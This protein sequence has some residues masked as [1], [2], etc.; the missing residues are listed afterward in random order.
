M[1]LIATEGRRRKIAE[2]PGQNTVREEDSMEMRKRKDIFRA[3]GEETVNNSM[4]DVRKRTYLFPARILWTKG[5]VKGAE[6]L[7]QSDNLQMALRH[8]EDACSMKNGTGTAQKAS[9]LLDFGTELHGGIHLS[10][11]QASTG[12]KNGAKLRIRFGESVSEAMSETGGVTNATND[13]AARDM[14]VILPGLSM[15]PIGETGFRFVRIDLEEEDAVLEIKKI[16]AV[17][18]YK[19]LEYQ[20]SFECSDPLLNRIWD[21]GA[22]TVHLNAQEYLLEGIKRDRLVWMGDMHPETM[23]ILSVFGADSCV[24]KSLDYMRDATELPGW[25]NTMATYTMWYVITVHAWYLFTGDR[26]FLEKHKEYLMG[27]SRMLSGYID[28]NGKDTVTEGRFLDWPSVGKEKPVDAG[29]QS[30]HILAV[31]KLKE[32]FTELGEKELAGNCADDLEKLRSCPQEYEDS[33]QAAAFLVLAGM[34]DAGEVNE[35]LLKVGGAKGMSTFMGYYILTARAMAGDYAGCLESIREYYGGMLSLGATTFWE[36]FDVDWLE[37]AGRIDELP[38]EGKV[39]V[40]AEKGAFCYQGHRHSLCHGW[41]AGVTPWLSENVLGI[42]ILEPGCKKVTV[43]PHLGDL[44]WAKGAYPTPY[45]PIRVSHRKC[46]D[47]HV[48]SKV[49][50]PESVLLV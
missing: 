25:M 20:G 24:E 46:S 29:A 45:G 6:T 50:V 14:Q 42:K 13:H 48:E 38:T 4:E 39:D 35:K 34:E 40:H 44:D 2:S 7:L 18:V 12:G 36:D 33:K 49:S 8:Y 11:W 37:N 26:E 17:L 9:L 43:E 27:V 32:L 1:L 21:V 41:A 22:Y 31:E 19:D 30:L 28:E 23:A 16:C 5:Q 3:I 10:L 47:G 15:N